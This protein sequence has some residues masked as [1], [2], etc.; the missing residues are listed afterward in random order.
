MPVLKILKASLSTLQ[1]SALYATVIKPFARWQHGHGTDMDVV[2]NASSII[3]S[4]TTTTQCYCLLLLQSAA[5]AATTTTL[6]FF[7]TK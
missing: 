5:A 4:T 2:S 1:P 7:S 6:N 3:F